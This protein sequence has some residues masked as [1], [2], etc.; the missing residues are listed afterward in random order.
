[1][2]P[3][4]TP[5]MVPYALVL[6]YST[7]TIYKR[8]VTNI[9]SSVR[10]SMMR[11]IV[12]MYENI[13]VKPDTQRFSFIWFV[14]WLRKRTWDCMRNAFAMFIDM[15]SKDRLLQAAIRLQCHAAFAGYSCSSLTLFF[16][17]R[18]FG[19]ND[20]RRVSILNLYETNRAYRSSYLSLLY[21]EREPVY[22]T[23]CFVWNSLSSLDVL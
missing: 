23:G 18:H 1:M 12:Q 7:E 5:S 13:I 10:I 9:L 15:L 8:I 17:S 22:Y 2:V 21:W 4:K 19:S 11:T 3:N 20:K 6:K 14:P 16:A